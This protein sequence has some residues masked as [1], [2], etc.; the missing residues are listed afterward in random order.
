[1]ILSFAALVV[2]SFKAPSEGFIPKLPMIGKND[3]YVRQRAPLEPSPVQKLPSGS[4]TGRGWL[5]V[6]LDLQRAGFMGHLA[7]ISR[8]LDPK[9]NA[10]MGTGDSKRGGWEEVPYWLKGQ[11]SLGYV[12]GDA[13]II[14]EVKPWIEGIIKSQSPDGWFGPEGNRKTQYGTP[15]LWPNMLAQNALQTYY[16]A[17]GDQRVIKLMSRYCDYLLSLDKKSLFDPRHY[18][19]YM[20][21]GDQLTS[22]VWLYNRTGESKILELAA[23]IHKA[24]ANWTG[25]V[26]NVHGVNFGQ[27]FREPATYSLFSKSN[28]DWRAT[29]RDLKD[30][31]DEF[32]QVP[33]GMYGA[34]ENARKGKTDPRQAAESCAI[35]EMMYSH[36]LL[37]E[38][39]GDPKWGDR[40]EDVAFNWM[41]VTMTPDLKAIRYLQ[42]ANM[43]IS[44]SPSKSPGVE[45]GGPMFL[46]DPNDHRCCQHNVGMGWPF[47]T[48]HLWYGTNGNGLVAA[49]LAPSQVK[50][51]VGDGTEVTVEEITDYPFKDKIQFKILTAK[52]VTFPL[53]VR[54]PEWAKHASATLDG[55]PVRGMGI[56]SGFLQVD[57]TWKSGDTLTVTLPMSIKLE[58]WSERPGAVSVLRGPLAYSLKI[59]EEYKRQP[60]PNGWD[61]YEIL[62]KST[63]NYGLDPNPKFNVVEKVA[64]QGEQPWTVQNAPVQLETTGR[65]IPEWSFDMYG[66]VSPLQAMP[67][68]TIEPE[69]KLTLI[70][71]G[72]ARLRISV[73]PTVA[74]T[75]HLWTKPREA[76]RPI[77]AKYSFR[78]WWDSESAL[79]DGLLPKDSNDHEIPRFTWYNHKGT[80]EWVQYT[81]EAN[82]TFQASR[83]F[84]FDDG[85]QGECRIPE[86]WKL[87]VKVGGAWRDVE[88]LEPYAISKDRWS[89]VKFKPVAGTEIRLIAKLKPNYSGGILEWEIN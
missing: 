16:E 27:G 11:V 89:E 58:N 14:A 31:T 25:G 81:F 10:W 70:P 1:V 77:P 54:I 20:R 69:T 13:K 73:F 2:L 60:R 59:E 4:V 26:A 17:T 51:R 68:K 74:P 6:Q 57:R 84:W 30:F 46:M 45:N 19:H 22:L 47:L 79:S 65:R 52:S 3:Y 87:Q 72:A 12:T 85:L 82:R 37:F 34:D 50:A 24:G 83:V 66:L 67:A 88:P 36:E 44:D 86:S 42:A 43:A 41:P 71:M 5:K 61:A 29:E 49:I 55:K 75:G 28:A 8:F 40:A 56:G 7:E 15:D 64:K 38:Y 21:V 33:G 78:N 80:E 76:K 9:N 23:R 63:W 62:P 32:G 35:A 18:W 39:S 53:Y 48:E